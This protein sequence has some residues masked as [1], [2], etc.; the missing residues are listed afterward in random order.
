M[1]IEKQEIKKQPLFNMNL[2]LFAEPEVDEVEIEDVEIEDV[3]GEVDELEETQEEEV[4]EDDDSKKTVP[5]SELM[6]ERNKWKERL[7]DPKLQKA[8]ALAEKLAKAT[9][10]DISDIE[11]E[12]DGIEVQ[13]HVNAGVDPQYAQFLVQQ[14]KQMEE[15]QRTLNKQKYDNEFIQI[16]SDPFFFDAEDYRDEI[17]TY[18]TRT[19]LSIEQAYMALRGKQRMTEF[20]RELE[21]KFLNNQSKKQSK[22]LDTTTG[23]KP[24]TTSTF[25]LSAEEKAI[26]KAAGMT[27]KEYYEFKNK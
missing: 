15:F 1:F 10:K 26:A 4:V 19:G 2:Q 13:K 18:S 9:G 11:K 27:E 8:L 17:E 6:K 7:N 24:Q 25:K 23:G 14:Q 12:L 16:K 20:Q 22:R 21:Q 3:E 5:L